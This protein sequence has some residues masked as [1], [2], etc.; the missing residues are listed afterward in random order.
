MSPFSNWT[1][2]FLMGPKMP[3]GRRSGSDQVFP[4]SAEVI[5]IPHHSWGLGPT[6]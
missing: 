4:P 5:T 6:L 1:G 3:S 2:L